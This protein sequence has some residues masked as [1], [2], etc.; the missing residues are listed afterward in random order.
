MDGLADIRQIAEQAYVY[1]YSPVMAYG[2]T[3]TQIVTAPEAERQPV[4]TW[5]H[6]RTLA[7]PDFNNYIPWVN[8]DT[9]YSSSWLDLRAEPVVLVTPEFPKHRFQNIQIND[10]Y[11]HNI[12]NRGTRTHG[13]GS[14]RYLIAGPG[15]SGPTPAGIDEVIVGESWLLKMFARILVE[16]ADENWTELHALQDR[17][18]LHT[19]SAWLKQNPPPPVAAIDWVV[20]DGNARLFEAR[21]P[22]FIC[23]LNFVLGM[24]RIHESEI[25][26]MQRFSK[27]GIDPGLDFDASKLDT[28]RRNAIQAGIDAGYERIQKRLAHLDDPV[29]GWVYPLNLR[30]PRSILAGSDD[31]FLR[32]AV[33]AR[34]AIWGPESAE[35][36]YMTAEVDLDGEPLDGSQHRYRFHLAPPPPVKG[37]WSF[38]VYDAK[39]RLLVKHPSG[40]YKIG[41]RDRDLVYA[42]DGSL[43]LYVQHDSPGAEH[44]ANWLPAPA[45]PFQIVARL[46]WPEAE[47]LDGRYQPPGLCKAG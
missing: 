37:F 31:A 47:L 46:Y 32:R 7:T 39:T 18:E 19:L 21:T 17:F 23:Y 8:T 27:I 12:V 35:V 33:L 6:F 45:M 28:P 29:N 11:G 36:V 34:Y 43:T 15:W 25:A 14:R 10:V 22:N 3:Y 40:R 41:D 26:L 16:G 24:C 30:G 1:A 4:N 2:L 13:N 42:A 38:T 9:V 44:Q 20:P 5:K